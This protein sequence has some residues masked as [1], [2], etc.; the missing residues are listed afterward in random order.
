M[1]YCTDSIS[2]Q[3]KL[4][5]NSLDPLYVTHIM[6]LEIVQKR[7]SKFLELKSDEIYTKTEINHIKL[8]KTFDQ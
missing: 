1:R 5:V 3:T 4:R 7:F 8:P 6:R 2:I